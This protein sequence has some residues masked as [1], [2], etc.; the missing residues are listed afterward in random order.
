MLVKIAK[1]FNVST[2]FLLG[3]SDSKTIDVYGLNDEE[4]AYIKLFI[5][6]LKAAKNRIS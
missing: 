3:L 2:D 5:K 6:D 4:I 1:Y